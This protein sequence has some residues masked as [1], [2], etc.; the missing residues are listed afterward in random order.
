MAGLVPGN[1][2]RAAVSDNHDPFVYAKPHPISLVLSLAAPFFS[3]S[4]P[5]GPVTLYGPAADLLPAAAHGALRPW[6]YLR[7]SCCMGSTWTGNNLVSQGLDSAPGQTA[8]K[9]DL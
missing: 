6:R 2:G 4:S 5:S 9:N 8:F 1:G 7:P 3:G